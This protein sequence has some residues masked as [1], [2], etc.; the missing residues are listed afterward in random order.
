MINLSDELYFDKGA[1]HLY[2]RAAVSH[3]KIGRNKPTGPIRSRL[4]LAHIIGILH[5]YTFF[6]III[7]CILRTVVINSRDRFTHI[8]SYIYIYI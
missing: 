4:L 1:R 8:G 7:Y 5:Y 3:E 6:I 2:Y